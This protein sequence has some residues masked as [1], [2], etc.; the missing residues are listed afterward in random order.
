LLNPKGECET[1]ENI[2][3]F[4]KKNSLEKGGFYKIINGK[5][6]SYKGW[7]LPLSEKEFKK[8]QELKL[9]KKTKVLFNDKIIEIKNVS[10]FCRNNN[11]NLN[12]FYS[13]LKGRIKEYKGFKKND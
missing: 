4:C 11:L 7:R 10:A 12:N 13:M 9:G 2:Y 3:D 8:K 5:S 6:L 1:I